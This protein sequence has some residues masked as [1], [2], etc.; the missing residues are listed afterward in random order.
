MTVKVAF[1]GFIPSLENELFNYQFLKKSGGRSVLT[2]NYKTYFHFRKI[3]MYQPIADCYEGQ[4]LFITGGTGFLG[5]V[6]LLLFISLSLFL[7]LSH[8]FYCKKMVFGFFG[9]MLV[10]LEVVRYLVE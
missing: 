4:S 9:E 3:K 1:V 10:I 6:R 7:F 8:F 5:K 2:L